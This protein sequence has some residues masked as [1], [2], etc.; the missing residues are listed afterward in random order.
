MQLFVRALATV[1][2]FSG[3]IAQ[4]HLFQ[5]RLMQMHQDNIHMWRDE[6]SDEKSQLLSLNDWLAGAKIDN[7]YC[8]M[9]NS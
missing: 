9:A 8:S 2:E 6:L 4:K 1:P 5:F 3:L 7:L